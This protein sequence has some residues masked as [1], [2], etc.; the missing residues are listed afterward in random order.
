MERQVKV[1]VQKWEPAGHGRFK[2][3]IAEK[4]MNITNI[5]H[6][7]VPYV[8]IK[9]YG[10]GRYMVKQDPRYV[11]PVPVA[12]PPEPFKEEF[13]GKVPETSILRMPLEYEGDE[14]PSAE[15]SD[16]SAS[17]IESLKTGEVQP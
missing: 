16:L 6:G 2:I 15:D 4:D 13:D 11:K 9:R 14:G 17:E 5:V 8:T 3:K 12:T 1:T 10:R 7:G